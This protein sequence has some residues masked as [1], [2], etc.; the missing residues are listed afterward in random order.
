MKD[1]Q[2]VKVGGPGNEGG[3]GRGVRERRGTKGKTSPSPNVGVK[4]IMTFP[5]PFH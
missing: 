5:K 2:G 4:L 3:G 1:V